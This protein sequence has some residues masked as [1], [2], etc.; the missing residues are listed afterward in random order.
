MCV[1]CKNLGLVVKNGKVSECECQ[2]DIE[3][4]RQCSELRDGKAL[5]MLHGKFVETPLKVL[6]EV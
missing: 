4:V 3:W 6:A 2:A 5:E 1:N